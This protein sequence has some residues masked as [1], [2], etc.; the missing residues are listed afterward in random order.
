MLY[1][2][3]KA[4]GRCLTQKH[5]NSRLAFFHQQ[6]LPRGILAVLVN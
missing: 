6:A 5:A 4:I 3:V 2:N 1:P